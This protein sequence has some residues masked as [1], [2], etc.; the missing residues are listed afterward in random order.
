MNDSTAAPN[1]RN[2]SIGSMIAF[3]AMVALAVTIVRLIGELKGW[4]PAHFNKDSGGGGALVGIAWL[5]PVFGV[6]FAMQLASTGEWP[7]SRGRA[8]L[9][10][11]I[12]LALLIGSFALIVRFVPAAEPRKFV[13]LSAIASV[14]CMLVAW[15]GWPK[16]ACVGLCYG[17]ASRIPVA[18]VMYLSITKGWDTH[19]SKG[20]PGMPEMA[21]FE[22]W[23]TIGVV[24]Q[25]FMWVAITICLGGL[26]GGLAL[27]LRKKSA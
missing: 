21:P 16:L 2:V 20:A 1:G 12:A 25:M 3:P 22:K 8:I 17:I 4:A 14:V 27:L 23:V 9:F 26:F 24:P 5:I 7:A 6:V 10:P 11:L 13:G 15:R 18:A 19:Y